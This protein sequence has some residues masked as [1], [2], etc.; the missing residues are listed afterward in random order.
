LLLEGICSLLAGETDRADPILTH[1]AE[2]ATE[3]R[4]LSAAAIA[5]AERSLVAMDQQTGS[6]PPPSPNKQQMSS[7]PGD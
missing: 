3:A 4:A 5:L 1:A 6:R 2:V 7:G